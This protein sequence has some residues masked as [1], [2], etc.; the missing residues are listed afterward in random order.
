[1][2]RKKETQWITPSVN[3]RTF[4][5]VSGTLASAAVASRVFNA[6]TTSEASAESVPFLTGENLPDEIESADDII[7][8]VCQM[9][10]SRCGIRAKVKEGIL[11]K[12]GWKPLSPEQPRRGRKQ[13]P[14]QG[15]LRAPLQSRLSQ[16]SAGC[17]SKAR[18]EYRRSTIP[19]GS[20]IR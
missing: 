17:A 19:S 4:V 11:V 6:S 3:R 12:T 2:R 5:K 10:H 14:G 1:M 15:L 8:S 20:S 16:S 13:R 7:Y 9:C 18:P